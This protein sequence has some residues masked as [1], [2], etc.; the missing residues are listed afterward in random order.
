MKAK[1]FLKWLIEN[2]I[3]ITCGAVDY[4]DVPVGNVIQTQGEFLEM[5]FGAD[6]VNRKIPAGDYVYIWETEE[7]KKPLQNIRE[8]AEIILVNDGDNI[9][10][11]HID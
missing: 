6:N 2:D 7:N 10:L 4:I 8:K 3:E 9:W 5:F 1:D 11:F